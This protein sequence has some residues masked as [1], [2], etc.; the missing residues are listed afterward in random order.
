[1]V[2]LEENVTKINNAET[3]VTVGDIRTLTGKKCGDWHSCHKRGGKL[4]NVT[5][6]NIAVIPGL[7]A[8]I[9]S[10]TQSPQ[11]DFH[12][13]SEGETLLLRKNSTGIRF[14]KKMANKAGE[15][16]LPTTKFYKSANNADLLAPKKWNSEGKASIHPEGMATK[17]KDNT[18]TKQ[19]ATQK[20]H[21]NELHTNLVYPGEDSMHAT[22]KHLHYSVKGMLDICEDCAMAKIR[23]KLLHKV[24]EEHDLNPEK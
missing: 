18:T 2:K 12:V 10:V 9:F 17:K 1:M 19:I 23:H 20:I 8:N 16:F 13:R 14:D 7:Y 21:S 4:H 24:A 22:A 15:G 5:L 3:R 6:T 11:K